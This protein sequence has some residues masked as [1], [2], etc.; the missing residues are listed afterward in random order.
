[1]RRSK[2][3]FLLILFGALVFTGCNKRKNPA[4]SS[5][6]A[7][8]K[9]FEVDLNFVGTLDS[10]NNSLWVSNIRPR[11]IQSTRTVRVYTPPGY[12]QRGQ[13]RPFPTLYLLHDFGGTDT[14][15][16]FYELA[17]TLDR[18]IAFGEIQPMLVVQTDAINFYGGAFYT[19]SPGSARYFTMIDSQLVGYVNDTYNTVFG[20]KSRGVCGH[21]MGGYGALKMILTGNDTTFGSVSALSAPLAFE[22]SATDQ[23]FLSPSYRF[24]VFNELGVPLN[25]STAYDSLRRESFTDI[26]SL[27]K[28]DPFNPKLVRTNLLFAMAAAFSSVDTTLDGNTDSLSTSQQNSTPYFF[29]FSQTGRDAG[30]LFPFNYKG[31]LILSVWSRWLRHDIKTFLADPAKLARLDSV[32]LYISCG[33]DDQLGML[34]QNKTFRDTLTSKGFSPV[35][36]FAGMTRTQFSK[37]FFYEEYPGYPGRPADHNTFINDQLVKVL[38]FHSQFLDTAQVP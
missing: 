33:L 5:A 18:M 8:G 11:L 25:D 26:L 30:V 29:K 19:N 15:Y 27:F 32:P 28:P 37:K 7:R 13:G 34:E 1:M 4:G 20:K 38:K 16:G 31:D 17:E 21:G 36:S 6:P 24:A 23:G 2:A 35:S 9:V 12:A 22:G 3:W 14:Y 10:V